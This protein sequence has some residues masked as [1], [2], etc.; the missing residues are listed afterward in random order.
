MA[1]RS[2]WKALVAGGLMA[3]SL[4]SD[5]AEACSR[6]AQ[7]GIKGFEVLPADGSRVPRST[8]VWLR[9]DVTVEKSGTMLNDVSAVRL[10]DE[11]GKPVGLSSSAVRVTG[12][13]VSTLFVL[14]PMVMLDANATYKVELDGAVLT[15]FTTSQEVDTQPPELPKARVTEVKGETFGA[16]SCGGPSSVTVVLDAPGDINFLVPATT[17][18]ATMPA[19]ALAVTVGRD[20]TAVAVPEGSVDLRVIA[21]DLSGNMA[22]S[23]E[24]LTTFVPTDAVGCSS[25]AGGSGLLA[26]LALVVRRRSSG[27]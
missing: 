20:I 5:P 8:S 15:R 16:T 3:V 27:R 14:R 4:M 17:N 18:A 6:L 12:E 19:A 1:V 13:R 9:S 7:T 11:R 24:Q 2:V 22:M 23:S 26:L 21:F 25:T 10:L